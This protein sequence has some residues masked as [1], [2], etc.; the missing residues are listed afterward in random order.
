MTVLEQL[1]EMTTVVADTGDF[2]AIKLYKPTDA[3]TNPSLVYKA[4]AMPEYKH[5]LEDAVAYA[6]ANSNSADE[7]VEMALDKV[8]VNFGVEILKNVDRY[9]STEIDARLSFDIEGTV[10]KGRELIP[11]VRRS[12]N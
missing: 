5:L 9:V 11:Y 7:A 6:K 3:T 4:A 2:E 10:A 1:K 12:W 8:A